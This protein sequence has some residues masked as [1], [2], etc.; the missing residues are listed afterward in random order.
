[1]ALSNITVRQENKKKVYQAILKEDKISRVQLAEQLNLSFPTVTSNIKQLI[2]EGLVKEDGELFSTGGR[3]ASI[4]S[5]VPNARIS[6]GIDITQNHV[7]FAIVN[8]KGELISHIRF[9]QKFE[10]SDNYNNSVYNQLLHFLAENSIPLNL[11]LGAGIS[12]PGIVES[13]KKTLKYSHLL[14]IFNKTTIGLQ[15]KLNF[16]S[17]L[18]NDATAASLAELSKSD[19]S[20]MVFLSLSNSVGGAF[21]L[22]GKCV[23]GNNMH[24][25]EFGHLVFIPGGKKCYCGAKGHFDSYCSAQVLSSVCGGHLNTFFQKLSMNDRECRK[26]FNEY[27][28][29]LSIMIC[30]LHTAFDLPI[31]L[32]GYVGSYLVPY[33]DEI[34]QKV[35]VLDTFKDDTSYLRTCFY[36][37]EGAAIGSALHFINSFIENI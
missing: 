21:I 35:E 3:K 13:D 17:I 29:Y 36:K 32:G 19:D 37:Q 30:N 26:A 5:S 8:L 28:D 33:L 25:G 7:G 20:D 31:V 24:N 12:I 6:V 22:D 15:N 4:V 18:S 10:N 1:M 14:G 11:I 2:D 27:I 34:K 23:A 9:V 16:P